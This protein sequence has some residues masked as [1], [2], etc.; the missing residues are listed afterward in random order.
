LVD[1]RHNSR[2]ISRNFCDV[3]YMYRTTQSIVILEWHVRVAI[4][5]LLTGII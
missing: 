2:Y 5:I 1:T 3:L 4:E